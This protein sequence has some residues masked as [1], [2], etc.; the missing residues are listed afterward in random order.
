M[1]MRKV[2]DNYSAEFHICMTCSYL[3]PVETKTVASFECR[4]CLGLSPIPLTNYSELDKW[5][6]ED[7][8]WGIPENLTDDEVRSMLILD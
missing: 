3:F 6:R 7:G 2:H 8:Y 5:Y 4:Y 1:T